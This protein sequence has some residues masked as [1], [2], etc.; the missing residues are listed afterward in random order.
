MIYVIV[1]VLFT[2][3]IFGWYGN[4]SGPVLVLMTI[5]I[6]V[7][8]VGLDTISLLSEVKSIN[9]LI[10]DNEKNIKSNL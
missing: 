2:G 10:D 9:V 8:C 6:F 4:L 5:G 7:I 1:L 3:W